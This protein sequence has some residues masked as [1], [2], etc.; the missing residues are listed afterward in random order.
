MVKRRLEPPEQKLF[1]GSSI[2]NMALFNII[3][4]FFGFK[5]LADYFRS[6]E[7]STRDHCGYVSNI[8]YLKEG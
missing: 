1:S 2:A 6:T 7:R 5:V 8:V 3:I 4:D